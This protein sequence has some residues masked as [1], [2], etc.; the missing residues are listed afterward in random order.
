[1]DESIEWGSSDAKP[2]PQPPRSD[3]AARDAAQPEKE[4][5]GAIWDEARHSA[6]S[7][8]NEQ[9]DA[10][11]AG[12]D[13]V[14]AALRDSARNKPGQHDAFARVTESAADGLA[15]LSG[16]LRNKDVDTM[17]RD[18]NHFAHAQPIAFFGI[19]LATGFVA[20]RLVKASTSKH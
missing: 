6:R 9:K 12:I 8:L 5:A 16:Q 14:A 7:K 11:A 3:G 15:R 18:V 4:R 10:A 20:V 1:M 13:D 19:A 2:P 17:L